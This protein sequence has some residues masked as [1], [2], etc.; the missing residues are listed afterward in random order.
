MNHPTA[1]LLLVALLA[2]PF[3]TVSL[4]GQ[5]TSPS[6]S[7][8]SEAVSQLE[9][10]LRPARD[11]RP[12]LTNSA[13]AAV[14][15]TR[16]AADRAAALLWKDRAAWIRATRT[17]EMSA[18]VIELNGLRLRFESLSFGDT[19]QLPTGGRSL[20][21]SLHGGGNARSTVNDSQWR[22][23]LRLGRGYAP[24]EGIYLAPRAPTDTWNLWHEAHI[25]RFF[26]RLIENLIVLER[27][28]PDR[29]Y[30]M[31]Y[32]AGGDGVYQLAPRM[33]DRW[34][35]AAMMAGHPNETSPL[36]L[37]NVPF[38]LQAGELDSAYKRNEVAAEWGRK[39]DD[40]Q[41]ADPDGY[42]HFT[43]IHAGKRHWMDLEDKKAVPWM[44]KFTRNPFPLRIVWR[45]DDVTHDQFYWLAL[46]PGTAREGQE[47]FA[48]RNG[49]KFNVRAKDVTRLLIRLNDDMA[50]LD[51]PITIKNGGRILFSGRI[52][53]TIAI[54]VRTLEE[55]GDP[56][57]VFSGEAAVDL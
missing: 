12:P 36:G 8:S 21:L 30:V 49:A 9:A 32:S 44:E 19:N 7:S 54:L 10:W 47:I 56:R 40:L 42:V 5:S 51:Q 6:I 13:F 20:F 18:G 29:I 52:N 50:D 53:R 31:G 2:A 22:N 4:K 37:R 28:N 33:A 14:P 46:P 38:A 41:R 16:A 23:Q 11:E 27:V 25:D 26:D 48:E 17:N 15:L 55:R 24:S 1:V 39:L 45:Q 34:A 57:L 35:A 43:E 3:G